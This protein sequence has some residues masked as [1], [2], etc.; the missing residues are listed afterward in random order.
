[1]LLLFGWSQTV[2]EMKTSRLQDAVSVRKEW[3]KNE[4]NVEK[5][6]FSMRLMT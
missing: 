2:V 1:M 6:N 4:R 5:K 3:Q